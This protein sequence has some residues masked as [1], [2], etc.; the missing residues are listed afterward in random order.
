M[1]KGDLWLTYVKVNLGLIEFP[2]FIDWMGT[3]L[4]GNQ[5]AFGGTSPIN[6]PGVY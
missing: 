1:V 2:R 6:L 3:V 4:K 5:L